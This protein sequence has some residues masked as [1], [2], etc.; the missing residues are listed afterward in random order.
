MI[1][2]TQ[3]KNRSKMSSEE[4]I[5][6]HCSEFEASVWKPKKCRNCFRTEEEHKAP[7]AAG[8]AETGGKNDSKT[9]HNA[10]DKK[11]S[12]VD[13]SKSKL[14]SKGQDLPKLKMPEPNKA[15]GAVSKF[16]KG[17]SPTPQNRTPNT[18]QKG[19]ETSASAQSKESNKSPNKIEAESD[20]T[21]GS[22]PVS[23]K[24]KMN[25]FSKLGGKPSPTVVPK[26][27]VNLKSPSKTS[28]SPIPKS[29]ANLKS[30]G[31]KSPTPVKQEPQGKI[32][33]KNV[34]EA[35]KIKGDVK[36]PVELQKG[37]I[38]GLKSIGVSESKTDTSTKQLDKNITSKSD[39]SKLKGTISSDLKMPLAS[40]VKDG[41]E[42]AKDENK[43][44]SPKVEQTDKA[45]SG[46]L[47]WRAQLQQKAAQKKAGDPASPQTPST[48]SDKAKQ[49][50]SP[51]VKKTEDRGDK[52]ATDLKSK[53]DTPVETEKVK[54]K[55]A[56]DRDL[57]QRVKK[58][59][60][61]GIDK[62]PVT[63]KVELK[64]SKTRDITQKVK[65]EETKE[66]PFDKVQLKSVKD[67]KEETPLSP[68]NK[69]NTKSE[70]DTKKDVS[71][72]N[73]PATDSK[74][75]L[76]SNRLTQD[77]DTKARKLPPGET[78]KTPM[79]EKSLETPKLNV[80]RKSPEKGVKSPS[81][82][83][84]ELKSIKDQLRSKS[85]PERSP[86]ATG[87]SRKLSEKKP[88]TNSKASPDRKTGN[89]GRTSPEKK[90][91]I[92]NRVSPEKKTRV[93]PEKNVESKSRAS[94]EKKIE[95]K[96]RASPEKKIETKTKEL[97]EKKVDTKRSASPDKSVRKSPDKEKL[98][99]ASTIEETS[100]AEERTCPDKMSEKLETM[101]TEDGAVSPVSPT[102]PRFSKRK[103][104]RYSRTP[105][106]GLPLSKQESQD[107][108]QR[109]AAEIKILQER[110]QAM[111]T[112][113]DKLESANQV[114]SERLDRPE[115]ERFES[116][117][118][119][120]Y[121][122]DL[123]KKLA[124]MKE[125][126]DGLQDE[127][128]ELKD[129]V[130]Y[131]R[132]EM[133]EIRDQFREEEAQEY[134]ELQKELELTAKNCRILQFKL[135]KAERKNEQVESD[136]MQYE[137]RIRKLECQ[138]RSADDLQHIRE[139][140]DELEMAKEVSVRLHDELEMVEEK[141][142]RYEEENEKLHDQVR[143]YSNK[144]LMTEKMIDRLRA[145]LEAYRSQDSDISSQRQS[146]E[147]D[148]IPLKQETAQAVLPDSKRG[149]E[150]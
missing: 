119:K 144:L 115:S 147:G 136:R 24:D 137:D 145:E 46:P 3:V 39:T 139:L 97:P 74:K 49:S 131:L 130:E 38:P 110:L 29:D 58:V 87:D 50:E 54:L 5:N 15:P 18:S 26:S 19:K 86:L 125:L 53:F 85:S 63:E 104:E 37:K 56:K 108:V 71:V 148:S 61:R 68:G 64:S 23:F 76:I 116:D 40:H 105:S 101:D 69:S 65:K 89:K 20:K 43:T 14:S 10:E 128:E 34:G 25:L 129:D 27:D 113:N 32:S 55:S 143:E 30:P 126:C 134:R 95:T 132:N 16:T 94:P 75:S 117:D 123:Q 142:S 59:E 67:K 98:A 107:E 1:A 52:K 31:M 66:S 9:D 135:R 73:E 93:S 81:G 138:Y 124:E 11:S 82:S 127:N 22:S 99:N 8:I 140:E 84:L 120:Q 4:G 70:S 102:S 111:E 100:T 47:D 83:P 60:S 78:S 79:V 42:K 2:F 21:G 51:G 33:D 121:A 96:S 106:R 150:E 112:A 44:L 146:P 36:T 41:T 28:P 62:S 90:L 109:L 118:A 88:D 17:S 48:P 13:K 133:D 91:D 72:E 141:R 80:N 45:K 57:T 122:A 114:M 35:S 103:R 6:V 77:A 149:L 12:P 92:K 7:S